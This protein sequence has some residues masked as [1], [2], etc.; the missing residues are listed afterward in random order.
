MKRLLFLLGIVCFSALGC[1]DTVEVGSIAEQLQAAVT[2][3][4]S[5]I[6]T[7]L[8]DDVLAAM[9][10]RA[11]QLDRTREVILGP[12]PNPLYNSPEVIDFFRKRRDEYLAAGVADLDFRALQKAF[13]TKYIDAGGI[14][15][16]ANN[17]VEDVFLI[18]ARD[19]V[20]LMTSKYTEL[21]E[22][23]LLKHRQ[24]YMVLVRDYSDFYDV[25]EFQL[26]S[27]VIKDTSFGFAGSCSKSGYDLKFAAYPVSGNCVA[28]VNRDAYPLN[29][30]IHEFAH[31]LEP[32]MELLKPGFRAQ[33][34]KVYEA[35]IA[36]VG[37]EKASE[38]VDLINA[39]EYWA[40]GVEWWFTGGIDRLFKQH[41]LLAELIAEWF[42]RVAY[43]K[44]LVSWKI[45]EEE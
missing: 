8:P 14:A 15:I 39:R 22:R 41:P 10:H 18:A 4:A 37:K 17:K 19:A 6:Q 2:Q 24:F 7:T 33:Q 3:P 13:Y 1:D 45:V 42:P 35:R 25:P 26:D 30:F 5:D 34:K 20:L 28:H 21:R 16:V 40:Y 38:D 36:E 12:L 32:E 31:A 9:L 43:N 27:P 29:I 23:L 44:D 11:D